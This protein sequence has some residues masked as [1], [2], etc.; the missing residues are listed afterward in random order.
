MKFKSALSAACIALA[1]SAAANAADT[2]EESLKNA[3]VKGK[4]GVYFENFVDQDKSKDADGF[5]NSFLTLKFETAKWNNLQFGIAAHNTREL[6]DENNDFNSDHESATNDHTLTGLPE[7]YI[8]YHFN[9]DTYAVLGR[10]D[11]KNV[12]HFDDGQ[13]EG[14][15][16]QFNSAAGLSLNAGFMT[17]FA[18]MDYDDFEDFG[19]QN[20]HQNLSTNSM[21]EDYVLFVDGTYQVNDNASVRPFAYHQGDFATVL[22]TDAELSAKLND[23]ATIGARVTAYTVDADATNVGAGMDSDVYGI[24][25]YIKVAGVKFGLG[26][27]EFGKGLARPFWLA[28]YVSGFDQK[29][30]YPSGTIANDISATQ[31]TVE[32]K[33][34]GVK[35]RYG[36]QEWDGNNNSA[37]IREHELMLGYKFTKKLDLALRFFD[38]E[39]KNS[40]DYQKVESRLRYKF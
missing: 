19:R 20:G 28:D 9:E 6:Y 11:H 7:A 36:V 23:D 15:Y 16:V 31:A 21:T 13:S 30:A 26:H 10:F 40:T 8:K 14:G 34:A 32:F 25:P 1:T 35:V 24:F 37:D 33:V 39:N 4:A 2:F 12:T 17:Q 3:K 29:A 5:A 38:V 27:A 22:G 18:E